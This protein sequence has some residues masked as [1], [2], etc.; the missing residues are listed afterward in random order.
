M[1]SCSAEEAS[2]TTSPSFDR[3]AEMSDK[4]IQLEGAFFEWPPK[5]EIIVCRHCNE[6]TR[7]KNCRN[8]EEE[9]ICGHCLEYARRGYK[10]SLRVRLWFKI[11]KTYWDFKH[12]MREKFGIIIP[13]IEYF[14]KKDKLEQE[15]FDRYYIDVFLPQQN[16]S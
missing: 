8:W 10:E 16:R 12:F 15:R 14:N 2:D 11:W 13:A 7:V 3:S 5:I 4:E 1:R 6:F 9:T